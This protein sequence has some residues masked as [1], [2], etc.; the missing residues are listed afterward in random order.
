[1]S[2]TIVTTTPYTPHLTAWQD[3]QRARADM[4]DVRRG[5][6]A[7]T[8]VLTVLAFL[9]AG[10]LGSSALMVVG[11]VLLVCTS[12]GGTLVLESQP[13]S[14]TADRPAASRA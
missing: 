6:F 13:E 11:A 10:T 2:S 12:I 7:L 9:L 1:M 8:A 3:A 5:Y 4:A 14:A